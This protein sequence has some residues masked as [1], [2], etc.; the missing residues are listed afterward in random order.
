MKKFCCVLFAFAIFFS[1]AI[2]LHSSAASQPSVAPRLQEISTGFGSTQIL[3]EDG[4]PLSWGRMSGAEESRDDSQKVPA[5][6]E[7]LNDITDI[8]VSNT[9]AVALKK[10]GTL[11][12]WGGD[13]RV[14][15]ASNISLNTPNLSLQAEDIIQVQ[16]TQD[17][18]YALKKDGTVLEWGDYYNDKTPPHII[19]GLEQVKAIQGSF[20]IKE[21]GTVWTVIFG[22]SKASLFLKL[23]NVK[24]VVGLNADLILKED[25]TLWSTSSYYNGVS[26]TK[27]PVQIVGLPT[28]KDITIASDTAFALSEDGNLYGWGNN[29]NGTLGDGTANKTVAPK[30][31]LSNVRLLNTSEGSSNHIMVQKNDL[32]LWAWGYNVDGCLGVELPNKK[33]NA[34]LPVQ[35]HFEWPKQDVWDQFVNLNMNGKSLFFETN[36]PFINVKQEVMVPALSFAKQLGWTASLT[37]GTLTISNNSDSLTVTKSSMKSGKGTS[38]SAYVSPQFVNGEV[39]VP[40][41]TL[42]ETFGLTS[43]FYSSMKSVG[44]FN[45][46]FQAWDQLDDFGILKRTTG[47]PNN[48]AAF[49]YIVGGVSNTF[50]EKAFPKVN[51]AKNKSLNA[52]QLYRSKASGLPIELSSQAFGRYANHISRYYQLMLNAD[53]R[54]INKEW[55]AKLE[56]HTGGSTSVSGDKTLRQLK[57]ESYVNWIINNKV[58]IQGNVRPEPSIISY[59]DGVL[60]MRTYFQYQIVQANA[61]DYLKLRKDRVV[62]L[63]SAPT[64]KSVIGNYAMYVDVPLIAMP[65][66]GSDSSWVY[67]ADSL[68]VDTRFNDIMP[69]PWEKMLTLVLSPG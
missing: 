27:E 50:Y 35:V 17:H 19:S 31:I 11:W 13:G 2:P 66:F 20:F 12:R 45:N 67:W 68:K 57:M 24:K 61:S 62:Q 64:G 16:A 28:I 26:N 39:F 1:T 52:A 33:A 29:R 5:G 56:S 15:D 4:V 55:A 9:H 8:S 32:S 10:D 48:A 44:I 51:S 3:T 14:L 22:S 6:I 37:D 53:Y 54:T 7:G 63:I 23:N 69:T 46:S 38:L 36:K 40:L 34:A 60:Y 49:P 47:L 58:I 25:G 59:R 42:S 43:K 18:T 30:L 21:D 65:T 41:R